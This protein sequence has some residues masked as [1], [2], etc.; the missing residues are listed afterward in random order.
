MEDTIFS[1]TRKQ[2]LADGEQ[3]KLDGELNQIAVDLGYKVPVYIT[4]L[5]WAD[6]VKWRVGEGQDSHG[7]DERGR[8]HD[9]LFVMGV[10]IRSARG[11]ATAK[12]IVSIVQQDGRKVPV[13]LYAEIGP[14][15]IDDPAPALTIM[16][17]DDL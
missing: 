9:V 14:T 11:R 1:Y 10:A 7:Q 17:S 6:A 3:I 8:L 5:A 13:M 12:S 16:T 4:R 2:A 15:D